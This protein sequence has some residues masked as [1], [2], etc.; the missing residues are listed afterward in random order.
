MD[1]VL[2]GISSVNEDAIVLFYKLAEIYRCRGH[3]SLRPRSACGVG[4]GRNELWPLHPDYLVKPYILL[5]YNPLSCYTLPIG[6]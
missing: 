2:V 6:W 3:N 5:T 1:R 4:R